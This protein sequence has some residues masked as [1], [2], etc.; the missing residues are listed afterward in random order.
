[1]A[2]AD[3]GTKKLPLERK[4]RSRL[5]EAKVRALHRQA[6]QGE[7]PGGNNNEIIENL[8]ADL[9]DLRGTVTSLFNLLDLITAGPLPR[10]QAVKL[11]AEINDHGVLPIGQANKDRFIRFITTG[12]KGVAK[13]TF[14]P[15]KASRLAEKAAVQAT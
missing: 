14:V 12:I 1:M 10:E 3:N 11:L 7:I 15:T 9:L 2:M 8:S 4:L 13:N 5:T 6:E